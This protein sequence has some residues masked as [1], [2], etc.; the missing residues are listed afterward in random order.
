MGI[1]DRASYYFLNT[2]SIVVTEYL[3]LKEQ[4]WKT[5]FL[6]EKLES[7]PVSKQTGPIPVI[8]SCKYSEILPGNLKS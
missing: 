3:F 6:V 8:P 5:A 1:L 7:N 2:N 4:H